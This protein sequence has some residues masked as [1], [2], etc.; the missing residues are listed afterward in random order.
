MTY[1]RQP[2]VAIDLNWVTDED[3]NVLGFMRDPRTFVPIA[4]LNTDPLTGG[5]T[6]QGGD[7]IYGVNGIIPKT[8]DSAGIIAAMAMA[9]STGLGVVSLLGIEY[10]INAEIPLISGVALRGVPNA[11]AFG[12]SDNVP[13]FW[14]I[15]ANGTRF[16]I[17][18]GITALT[19]NAADLG[20]IQSPLMNFALRQVSI[21]G[22]AFV[23]GFRAIKIGAINAMGCVDGEIDLVSAYNQTAENSYA[24]DIVNSQFFRHGRVRVRENIALSTG[25]NYRIANQLPSATLLTGDSHIEEIFSRCTSL[26]RRGVVFE[27]S[28]VANSILNDIKVIGRIHASRY[29]SGTPTSVSMTTTSGVADISVPNATEY[30]LCQIGMPVRFQSTAPTGFDATITYFVVGKND[31]AKTVQLS[32]ADYGS[33]I[34]P[35]ASSTYATYIAGYPT[36]IA[37]ADIGGAV[38]NS[39]F[40]DLACEVTGNIGAVMFS[41]TRNCNTNLNNPSTSFTQ[42]SVICRDA[43]IGITY[44][45]ANNVTMD[46]SSLSAGLCNFV[47]LA[48]GA[49][50][51]TSGN[52]TLD[53]SWH[54]RQVRYSGTTDITVTIPRKLPRGFKCSFITTGATGIITFS[55]ASGLGL[56]SK[57]SGFRTNGQNARAYLESISTIG[58]HLSGDLQV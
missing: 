13:D 5:V 50:Q 7:G 2:K 39:N 1:G 26:T 25:G 23:G 19:W 21:T 6:L 14:T 17:S 54:G 57:I 42:S 22:I 28:G 32:E 46:E 29:G 47:N 35:T 49:Y 51:H 56:W 48:G 4:A 3:G 27:A 30:Q 31:G 44:S 38:K 55:P 40:G 58:Y 52:I 41:K 12:G 37:R 34:T 24:I 45:G 8:A 16:N 11:W 18:P 43:E 20:T 9:L 33:A 53:S 15:G 36:F 10:T